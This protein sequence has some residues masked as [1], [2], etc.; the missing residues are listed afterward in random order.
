MSN[1]P[2]TRDLLI[3]SP[4]RA[5]TPQKNWNLAFP[6]PGTDNSSAFSLPAVSLAKTIRDVEQGAANE[7]LVDV[8]NGIAWLRADEGNSLCLAFLGRDA[9]A[10][11][12]N[13]TILGG[14]SVAA[15]G[16][17]SAVIVPEHLVT[18]TA[19]LGAQTGVAGGVVSDS[20]FL[21]EAI[22]IGTDTTLPTVGAQKQDYTGGLARLWLDAYGAP[23][24]GIFLEVNTAAR[25]NAL[26]LSI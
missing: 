23:L 10:E 13:Y 1:D 9:A 16:D 21:A 7:T 17:G 14:R 26:V 11:T 5:V 8:A 6:S 24:I 15:S 20:D 25:A 18:G 4:Q 3:G 12:I 2:L 19:T 22:T